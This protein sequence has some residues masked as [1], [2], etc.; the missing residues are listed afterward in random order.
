MEQTDEPIGVTG[1]GAYRS[2]GDNGLPLLSSSMLSSSMLTIN[3]DHALM[4]RM[5]QP[6]GE[7]R[8]LVLPEL[9]EYDD[10]LNC[11]GEDAPGFSGNPRRTT[12]RCAGAKSG[13]G[14]GPGH[15]PRCVIQVMAPIGVKRAGA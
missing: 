10:W 13:K 12:E 8:M 5:R 11:R 15:P 9:E 6:E 3:A 4:A 1:I 7:T 14:I 2:D